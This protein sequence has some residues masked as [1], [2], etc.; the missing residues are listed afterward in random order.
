MNPASGFIEYT[1]RGHS[2]LY[3]TDAAR[4]YS[5]QLR[6]TT[7]PMFPRKGRKPCNE[8]RLYE[9]HLDK[10]K[11]YAFDDALMQQILDFFRTAAES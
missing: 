6:R 9:K 1:H 10:E 2:G 7:G 5:E 3:Y 11:K 4:E 8:S